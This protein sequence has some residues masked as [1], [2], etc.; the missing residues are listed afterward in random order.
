[1]IDYNFVLELLLKFILDKKQFNDICK[2]KQE[3]Q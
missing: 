2:I 3:L 1:M